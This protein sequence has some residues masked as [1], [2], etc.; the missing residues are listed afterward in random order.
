M[1]QGTFENKFKSGN[2]KIL[3]KLKENVMPIIKAYQ[4]T[5]E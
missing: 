3:S 5:K 4:I 1:V 2:E